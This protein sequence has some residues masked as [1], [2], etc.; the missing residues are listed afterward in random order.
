METEGFDYVDMG[1][2]AI[3]DA[4]VA[5]ARLKDPA[6]APA[7]ETGSVDAQTPDRAYKQPLDGLDVSWRGVDAYVPDVPPVCVADQKR[8]KDDK[9]L[10][11]CYSGQA[12][13]PTSCD[14]ACRDNACVGECE[15]GARRRC[16]AT[17][18]VPQACGS[19]NTWVDETACSGNTPYC[20]TGECVAAC[21]GEGQ[22]CSAANTACCA[23]SECIAAEGGTNLGNGSKYV[24]KAI[25]ACA[26]LG[27]TCAALTDCCAGLDCT[28]GKCVAKQTA[29]LESPAD[30]VCGGTSGGTC[31][32]GTTCG[33]KVSY[34]PLGCMISIN[35]YPVREVACPRERPA[36]HE[37]CRASQMALECTYS[38]W[39]KQPGVFFNCKCGYHGWSCTRGQYVH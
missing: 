16:R 39:A 7:K 4:G 1:C 37:A 6:D 31:C 11:T 12:W 14:F 19:A 5:D 33:N 15:P 9:V 34:E 28:A 35:L 30:G 23:G 36:F 26:A 13:L 8:C 24:C 22:D 25:P 32:P 21:L 2:K 27:A 18:N 38:D 17:G 10:E 3:P 20:A 29:C